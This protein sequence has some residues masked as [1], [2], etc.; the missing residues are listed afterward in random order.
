MSGIILTAASC[1]KND[2]MIHSCH[3]FVRDRR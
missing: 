1:A 3:S 2:I